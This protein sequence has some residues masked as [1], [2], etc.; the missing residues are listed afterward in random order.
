M[1]LETH[2]QGGSDKD[3][4]DDSSS[5]E[6][7]GGGTQRGCQVNSMAFQFGWNSLHGLL[8]SLGV[9]PM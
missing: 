9:S 1:E 8:E 2:K 7:G 5:V 4:D 3:T 6:Q